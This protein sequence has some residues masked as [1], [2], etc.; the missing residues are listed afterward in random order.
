MS[1]HL[2]FD[3]TEYALTGPAPAGKLRRRPV[4]RLLTYLRRLRSC[5]PA[6]VALFRDDGRPG[7]KC[8]VRRRELPK[9]VR[10]CKGG[11]YQARPWIGPRPDDNVNLGLYRAEDYGNDEEAAINA[12]AYAARTFLK[13]LAG[14][15]VGDPWEVVKRL[16][17]MRRFG[18]PVVPPHVLPRFVVRT[19]DGRYVARSRKRAGAVEV[20]PFD[21]PEEARRAMA[22]RLAAGRAA[23]TTR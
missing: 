17:G 10:W 18:L 15:P 16:Q 14:P 7:W 1:R 19:P 20:G 11:S 5:Y 4:P 8:R 6:H 13:L 3:P 22:E 2:L 21:T 9:H 23:V 12:A